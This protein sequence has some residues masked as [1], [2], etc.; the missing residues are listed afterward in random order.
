MKRVIEIT[1]KS[2]EEARALAQKEVRPGETIT[3]SDI[4]QEPTRGIFGI[5]GNPDVRIRFTI[6]EIPAPPPVAPKVV[7]PATP[8][9]RPEPE[10]DFGDAEEATDLDE[11]LVDEA[12][13]IYV[14][15]EIPADAEAHGGRKPRVYSGPTGTNH[16]DYEQL[17]RLVHQVAALVGSGEITVSERIDGD[18][19]IIEPNGDNLTPFIGK[20]G[21]TLDAIQYLVNIVANKG[22]EDKVKIVLDAQGYRD[23]RHRRLISLAHRMCRKVADGGRAVELEPMST[24]DRRTIHLALKDRTDIQTYSRGIEPMRRVVIAP[25]KG[26]QAGGGRRGGQRPRRYGG[27]GRFGGRDQQGEHRTQGE[28]NGPRPVPMFMGEDGDND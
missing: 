2:H 26:A 17:I 11:D 22:R 7:T 9:P 20:H 10:A 13:D 28:Q 16:P 1:A 8:S 12:E 4:L 23:S 25:R 5:V 21:R 15:E 24:V 18:A 14:D 6:D 27:P 19:W 3:Q